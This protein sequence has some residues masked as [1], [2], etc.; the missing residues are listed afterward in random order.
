MERLIH[1]PEGVR[2]IY[3][4]ECEKKRYLSG[5]INR[6]FSGYGYQNIETPSLEY[7]EVF[8]NQLGTVPSRELYKFFDREGNTLVLRPDFT[9]SIAR[10]ASMYF[11]DEKVPVRLCY[12]GNTFI[13][14]SSYQG[15]PKEATQM[16]VELLGDNSIDADAEI[17]AMVVELMLE[18]GLKE[19]QISVGSVDFFRSLLNEARMQPEVVQ[20]LQRL[21]SDKNHFGVE[22]LI[23]KQQLPGNLE[24]ILKKI[25]QLFGGYEVLET[26]LSL[27]GSS[28]AA[29][30]LQRLIQIY[31]VMKY[32]GYE[33]Y[34][35]FDLGMLTRY[36]YYTGIIFQ[37]YTYGTGEPIVKG[38]RYD[39]L[40]GYF[41][42]QSPAVGFGVSM[43]QLLNA[44]YRQNI[45]MEL[46]KETTMILYPAY[47]RRA[48][49]MLAKEHR[50]SGM[51]VACQVMEPGKTL[52]DYKDYGRRNRFGGIVYLQTEQTV[53]AINLSTDQVQNIDFCA[54]F[55]NI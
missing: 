49:I 47:M 13:N 53:Q 38:G 54:L 8:S 15:R 41:G 23:E 6:V 34:I 4:E 36:Q 14:H 28:K 48:A 43:D 19:F 45:K 7:F 17:L 32:Y 2:D 39:S 42:K 5:K 1:T 50:K 46:P 22:E 16:G 21:I 33:K 11:N 3:N 52:E 51:E 44:L 27:T 10:A 37:A 31:E 55:P 20:E 9:P 25:P 26:A 30:C 12:C 40:L 35:S 29:Q 18:S 24:N